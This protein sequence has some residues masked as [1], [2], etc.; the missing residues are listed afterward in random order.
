MGDIY[1]KNDHV[2]V[3]LG[4]SHTNNKISEQ[5]V[6][7]IIKNLKKYKRT[8]SFTIVESAANP[9]LQNMANK[10][11][12]SYKEKYKKAMKK[13]ADFYF[14]ANNLFGIGPLYFLHTELKKN[15]FNF[16][17]AE[18]RYFFQTVL[19]SAEKT[20]LTTN[21]VIYEFHQSIEQIKAYAKEIESSDIEYKTHIANFYIKK[22]DQVLSKTKGC[23][24]FLAQYK[25]KTYD[26]CIDIND[27]SCLLR[28][29]ANKEAREKMMISAKMTDHFS[30]F[31]PLLD[32]NIIHQ[33]LTNQGKVFKRKSSFAKASE[34]AKPFISESEIQSIQ[35]KRKLIVVCAG[36]M[37][38]TEIAQFLGKIGYKKIKHFGKTLP[39][40][41]KM[42]SVKNTAFDPIGIDHVFGY[43]H[44]ILSPTLFPCDFCGKQYNKEHIKQCARCKKAC[45]CGRKCQKAHWKKGH[46]KV[47]KKDNKT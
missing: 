5:Q 38:T 3:L 12:Y 28:M 39:E 21:D 16:I 2:V 7:D 23:I 24:G 46:K 10:K 34:D 37:H 6:N 41:E 8:D 47:C 36:F 40:M 35:A 19:N 9:D 31:F 27:R 15:G 32:I 14:S 4:D 45:Y 29:L 20:A 25:N 1:Q 33:I 43:V 22:V 26:F 11:I 17:D 42:A 18:C 13:S 44:K 30:Q